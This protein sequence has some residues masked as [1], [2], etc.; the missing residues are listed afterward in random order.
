[1]L[2]QALWLGLFIFC[3]SQFDHL[4]NKPIDAHLTLHF[5]QLIPFIVEK[6]LLEALETRK[7]SFTPYECQRNVH[8][9]HLKFRFSNHKLSI[10]EINPNIFRIPISSIVPGLCPNVHCDV[11]CQGFP[12][13]RHI[14]HT[15][16]LEKVGV[17][18]FEFNANSCSI[19]LRISPPE[20]PVSIETIARQYIDKVAY[21]S[22]PAFF[23]VKVV[24][25]VSET[26][27]FTIDPKTKQLTSE[28]LSD[29][30]AVK[31][32]DFKATTPRNL[33]KR[34]AIAIDETNFVVL[35]VYHSEGKTYEISGTHKAGST[36]R[37]AHNWNCTETFWYL[38]QLSVLKES[39]HTFESNSSKTCTKLS[40]L[41]P[42]NAD[43]FSLNPAN[44][45]RS[46]KVVSINN[47]NSS[48]RV[49]LDPVKQ[50]NLPMVDVQSV[51]DSEYM[52]AQ[53]AT[54]YFDINP[55]LFS[56]ITGTLYVS[57]YHNN[58]QQQSDN[59]QRNKR[60]DRNKG[61]IAIGLELKNNKFNLQIPGWVV[62]G[63]AE[64][65]ANK[66]LYSMKVVHVLE[67]YRLRFPEVFEFIKQPNFE[68]LV[69][70]D[71]LDK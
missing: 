21:V 8:G 45:G 6:R 9:P 17:R 65:Y 28:S 14:D 58:N 24:S 34:S 60:S 51:K 46:G 2:F 13:F 5:F 56:R 57:L 23:E 11:I 43:V 40:Q 3:S 42:Q 49:A 36:V 41:F 50:S 70:E 48:I 20:T 63:K 55:L 27:K 54:E 71:Y 59:H 7:S 37:L 25:V 30:D 29:V 31:M 35:E 4:H 10:T 61:Q 62:K 53:R 32:K 66:W 44:Y 52:N 64:N 67:E 47:A 26:H 16:T 15:F 69:L 33:F 12:T 22:W 68:S 39:I 18:I 19:L 1:M 38:H